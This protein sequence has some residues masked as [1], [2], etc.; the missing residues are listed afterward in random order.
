MPEIKSP[1]VSKFIDDDYLAEFHRWL[2][3]G[4]W[5]RSRPGWLLDDWLLHLFCTWLTTTVPGGQVLHRLTETQEQ[6]VFDFTG[7][8]G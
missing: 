1:A 8:R 2:R 4:D 5:P 7:R 6:R 3:E